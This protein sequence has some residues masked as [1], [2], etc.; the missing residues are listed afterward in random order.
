MICLYCKNEHDPA[1]GRLCAHC[2]IAV[3]PPT[4]EKPENEDETEAKE[5]R[6]QECGVPARS[7]ASRCRAC[8][9]P[10][11]E[12]EE[13]ETGPALV[14]PGDSLREL[15][16]PPG[17][18]VEIARGPVQMTPVTEQS[19]NVDLVPGPPVEVATGPVQMTPPEFREVE[20]E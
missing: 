14:A 8:G 12:V 19:R 2:G 11:P 13:E 3:L 18:P 20:L 17:P 15:E 9:N 4:P 16:L 1:V 10:L 7:E 5:R 6:C